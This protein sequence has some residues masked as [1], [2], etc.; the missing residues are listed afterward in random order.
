M[1]PIETEYVGTQLGCVR[2][3]AMYDGGPLEAASLLLRSPDGQLVAAQLTNANGEATACAPAGQVAEDFRA[4]LQLGAA[5]RGGSVA[6]DIDETGCPTD[7]AL[8]PSVGQ[9]LSSA[10]V[11]GR[12]VAVAPVPASRAPSVP[13]CEWR[14]KTRQSDFAPA[15][16]KRQGRVRLAVKL[17]C[18]TAP[19]G[20]AYRFAI[21]VRQPGAK[22]QV[23]VRTMWLRNQVE[24]PFTLTGRFRP[25]HRIAITYRQDPNTGIPRLRDNVTLKLSSKRP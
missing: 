25:G 7:V 5:G 18:D 16:R 10:A 14:S 15:S 22:R 13:T 3:R 12:P 8:R 2:V 1:L 19:V 17:T 11:T 6:C 9:M 24:Q 20:R 21:L 23:R 4:S